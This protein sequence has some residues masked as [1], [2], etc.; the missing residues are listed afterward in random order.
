MDNIISMPSLPE[1]L[2]EKQA[3]SANGASVPVRNYVC[4]HAHFYQPPRE[5]PWLE[6][7][8]VQDSAYP[9]HDWNQRI[10]AE[11]YA[12]NSASRILDNEGRIQRIVNNYSNISF[13]FGPTL[14]S[15]IESQ[16]SETYR[17]ILEADRASR[18]RFSG[19]G[20]AIAQSYNHMIMPLANRR[21]KKTQVLWGIRDFEH[22]F[23]RP[24]EGMWLP[25]AAVDNDTLEV[26]AE[27]GIRFTILA[28][29]QA[30]R[31][32]RIGGR[33]WTELQHAGIDPS[34]A[35]LCILP[36]GRRI[37]I[38]F[39]DG[40]ISQA[41]AFERLLS[42]GENF[43]QRLLSGL[44]D[45]RTWPQLVHIA[46][47]GESY[48]HHHPH[49][50]MALGYALNRISNM[51]PYAAISAGGNGSS[52]SV[53]QSNGSPAAAASL[54]DVTSATGRPADAGSVPAMLAAQ[55]SVALTNYGEFLE[56]YP[57]EH[58]V[59]VLQKS[60]WSCYHGVE[61]WMHD[62][63][64]NSG[65]RDWRQQWRKPLRTALDWLRDELA[66]RFEQLAGALLHDSWAARDA[67]IE[68]VLNRS[69]PNINR[70]LEQ[71]A[72]SP[73][74]PHQRITVLKL[75]EMQRHLM[76]MYTSCAW[77]FD[78]VSG[79][80]TVQVMQYAA[81]ALQLAEELFPGMP[82]E[83]RFLELLSQAP[84]NL[85]HLGNAAEIYKRWI[86]HMVV[87]LRQVGAHYALSCMFLP[88]EGKTSIFCYDV[89]SKEFHKVRSG[90]ATLVMGE[91]N[92]RS[93]ITTEEANLRFAVLYTGDHE[94]QAGVAYLHDQSQDFASLLD[95]FSA[96]FQSGNYPEL[97]HLLQE[98]FGGPLYSLNSLFSEQRRAI[99]Q[100]I[101]ETTLQESEASYRRIYEKHAPL[102]RF[103]AE[104][105]TPQPPVFHHTAEFVIN[106]QLRHALQ[107]P[108]PD[109]L[110]VAMMLEA[111][112]RDQVT[113]EASALGVDMRLA[114]E[115]LMKRL[116]SEPDDLLVLQ[117]AVAA[118]E[119][120]SLLPF[121][122]D[123]WNAQNIYY[124][125]MQKHPLPL[126]QRD[127][128][129]AQPDEKRDAEEALRWHELFRKLGDLL[130]VRLQ[131]PSIQT[132]EVYG[133][134]QEQSKDK[135]GQPS[136]ELEAKTETA[137]PTGTLVA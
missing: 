1:P 119:L 90:P 55:N 12:P 10:N 67:Y 106:Q 34:R 70:F 112:K 69:L 17:A 20:S 27:A 64:C 8:E 41:V 56:R 31:V 44:S 107:A 114:L 23:G 135:D 13:N 24:P 131:E 116:E 15:W 16:Q 7:V 130:K 125:L 80:E 124:E 81:R 123:L 2:E 78:E 46:T 40:P 5:N 99:V 136:Q 11:C 36:S 53:S 84:S 19:H 104:L 63:G 109:L 89:D 132:G 37:N 95:E 22:R 115:R 29:R 6:A 126:A 71:H 120:A 45:G 129:S 94:V 65:R 100:N 88:S 72:R 25:E 102:M 93:Q 134:S 43:V 83:E 18:E 75:L 54:P 33:R 51:G 9:F 79:I 74:D 60:S 48:G 87:D 77:F 49:G 21:D 91:V 97:L 137:A 59:E 61:R 101:L 32:R 58:Q 113:L 76:L 108:E 62:C 30:E 42:N 50:D 110:Q 52:T 118:V 73:V 66:P 39:Y 117:K 82:L 57:A 38:F 28:P 26:L 68:V 103:V 35:Y 133:Q 4:I 121:H 47:D 105:G 122:V 128:Q 98:R 86:K 14:L 127:E 111:A 96:N 92:I 3:L 85:P